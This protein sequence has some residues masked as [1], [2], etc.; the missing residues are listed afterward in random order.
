MSADPTTS[1]DT[2]TEPLTSFVGR[3]EE[4]RGLA[5]L[6]DRQRLVTIAGAGGC[7]KTRL[8]MRVAR[9]RAPH[10]EHG[11]RF[12]DLGGVRDGAGLARF[13]NGRLEL[14]TDPAADPV[15]TLASHLADRML[16]LVLDTCEHLLDAAAAL[17]VP[18]LARCPGLTVLTTSREPLGVDG[19]AV[20]RVPPL[21]DD[22]AVRLFA[23]RARLAAPGFDP[24]QAD[25]EIRAICARVDR[26][27]LGIELAAAWV[28]ALTPD[29]IVSGLAQSLDLRTGAVR[30]A[31]P[32]HQTLLASMQWSHSLLSED[33]QLFFRRL[34]VFAGTFSIEAARDVCRDGTERLPRERCLHLIAR[35]ADQSLL[36]I[37]DQAGER[38]YRML[39]TV[40]QFALQQLDAAA[41]TDVVRA[42]HL[43]HFLA[44]A[45]HH[46][47]LLDR[48]QDEAR[49]RLTRDRHDIDTALTWALT[50]AP[51]SDREAV[52]AGRR[53]A[54]AMARYWL[55]TGR[56]V[57]GLDH[58][59]RAI[60][61]DPADDSAL[62]GRLWTGTAM[63][64][65]VSGRHDVVATAAEQGRQLACASGDSATAARCLM[66][67]AYPAFFRD[68]ARCEEIA[69]HAEA[70]AQAA[71][72]PFARDF[73][74]VLRGYS[75]QTRGHHDAATAVARLAWRDAH[76][77][78]DRFTASFARGI[79]IFVRMVTGDVP[80]AIRAGREAVATA[81]PLVDYFAVGTNTVNA[82]L[83]V[84]L[85]GDVDGALELMTPVIR[86]LEGAPD[87]DVVG[88]PVPY[89]YAQ[90]WR[91]R[92]AD[93][94]TWLERGAAP[95]ADGTLGWTAGRSLPGLVGAL[96]RMGRQ[97]DA[98]A[99]AERAIA[100]ERA[101][102]TPFELANAL[103]EMG[104]LIRDTDR[105]RAREL[106][107][108]ALATRMAHGMTTCYVDSLEALAGLA[109]DRGHH[110]EAIRL[111][112]AADSARERL[113]YP[114]PAVDEDAYAAG[115][116]ALRGA[117]EQDDF[118]QAWQEG[119][120]LGL[121]DAV[122]LVTRGRGPRNRPPIGWE[123]LS[124]TERAV[125]ELVAEGHSNPEIARALY[126][127]RSTVKT[128]LSH[129][130]RKLSVTNRAQ[131]AAGVAGRAAEG[132]P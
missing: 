117:V 110:T 39:D 19:E 121:G 85:S 91:G 79:E 97:A 132:A 57:E 53:L 70:E 48:E 103:D 120:S 42:R 89:G 13:V 112:A 99:L 21:A 76:P 33:E 77:R 17:V 22:D 130:Y 60:T 56:T 35:L 116:S 106:Y 38:R 81:A 30:T 14:L 41:E 55:L 118:D 50:R 63:L 101:F 32:R 64:A 54:A 80:G 82:A 131:L 128:H 125:A 84:A 113:C 115:L 24:A 123:S 122:E 67:S 25:A 72:D 9:D 4:L 126:M 36:T 102:G 2:F 74:R 75:L 86:A 47:P 11:A 78:G 129:I 105:E 108:D 37:Q 92:L 27:P 44:V 52:T 34:G 66:L 104:H 58:L 12:V 45:E 124:H 49:D 73:A 23:D 46:E 107:H 71:D 3:Q 61:A 28:R 90:L 62:Q 5:S 65:L 43:K 59:G 98:V 31:A 83:P 111:L 20:W 93:A 26:M 68:F 109:S 7:G 18:L 119:L 16:L 114:R 40:R 100:A 95:L 94:A 127:S 8:A 6:I 69:L 88:F 96:R 87:A 1:A 51:A 29:Q 15:T 10:L